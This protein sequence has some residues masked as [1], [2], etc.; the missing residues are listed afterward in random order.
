MVNL[1]PG[2]FKLLGVLR[3]RTANAIVNGTSDD[4]IPY[5]SQNYLRR[6]ISYRGSKLSAVSVCLISTSDLSNLCYSC[7]LQLLS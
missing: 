5:I 6:L 4:K 2:C 3:N 1:T 7:K